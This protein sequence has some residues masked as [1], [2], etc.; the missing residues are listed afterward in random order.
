MLGG[1]NGIGRET[2]ILF[3][4]YGYVSHTVNPFSLTD[5]HR[6]AKVVI[7]DVNDEAASKVV[8]EIRELGG[9]AACHEGLQSTH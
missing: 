5:F 6:S 2:A 7:G 8:K 1:A 3:A 9:Y 4:R